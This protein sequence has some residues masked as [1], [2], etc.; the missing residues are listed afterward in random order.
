MIEL[1]TLALSGILAAQANSLAPSV[2]N[3]QSSVER[4]DH[5][6]QTQKRLDTTLVEKASWVEIEFVGARMFSG[7]QLL[8][9]MRHPRDPARPNHLALQAP[10][11]FERLLDDLER[12]R[13]F[14]GSYGFLEAKIGEPKLE[15]LGDHVKV[16]VS[17]E[18][19]TRYRIGSI[20]VKGA[21]LL[22]P[23]QIIEISGLRTGEIINAGIVSENIYNVIKNIYSDHGYIQADVDFI[24]NFRQVYPGAPEGIVD[25]KL[26]IEE[27]KAFF[28]QAIDFLGLAETD[29]QSLRDL[30]LIREGDLFSRRMF[31]ESLKSL[32]QRG[33]FEEVLEKHVITRTN[34]KDRQ[35][36]LTI[37]VKEIRRK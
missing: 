13:Y 3:P 32:N 37:Q 24:P 26:D 17:I 22:T 10:V 27:G 35:V 19:G 15:D 33:L 21:K 25:V 11:Y 28:I 34:D 20:S 16:T 6:R 12:V 18:E 2:S 30:L 29:E 5:D 9:Q 1:L 36:S 31:V 8:A 14:L 23:E 7:Q 4:Q